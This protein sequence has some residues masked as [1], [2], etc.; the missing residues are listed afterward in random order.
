M[1]DYPYTGKDEGCKQFTEVGFVNDVAYFND[2]GADLLRTMLNSFVVAVAIEAENERFYSYTGGIIT[3]GC[4]TKL[5]HAV[6]AVGYGV[7]ENGQ[8]YF[9]VKN[10]WGA[11]WGESG[12]ARIAPD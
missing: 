11:N 5:D 1:A 9:I 12:Y 7:D 2:G 4:G 10:S 6:T 8:Q 3:A